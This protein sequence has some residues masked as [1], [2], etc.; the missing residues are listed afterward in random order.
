MPNYPELTMITN[1]QGLLDRYQECP[2]CGRMIVCLL[3]QEYATCV[4]CLTTFRLREAGEIHITTPTDKEIM[5][6]PYTAHDCPICQNE[7]T[8]W[9]HTGPSSRTTHCNQCHHRIVWDAP[10]KSPESDLTKI[11]LTIDIPVADKHGLTAGSV[12]MAKTADRIGRGSPH[13]KVF[14]KAQEWVSI[15]SREYE[16]VQD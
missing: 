14:T 7:I 5:G 12:W 3:E 1:D 9:W 6:S 4:N 8:I 13:Y 16:V 11:R 10:V 15:N 2:D